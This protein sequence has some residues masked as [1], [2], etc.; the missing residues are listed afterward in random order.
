MCLPLSKLCTKVYHPVYHNHNYRI[1][2]KLSLSLLSGTI[3][4]DQ[5]SSEFSGWIE[6]SLNVGIFLRLLGNEFQ[7]VCAVKENMRS[8]KGF[9]ID[10]RNK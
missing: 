1:A 7:T 5:Q 3:N 6:K 2:T 4:P 10:A 8:P 9:G